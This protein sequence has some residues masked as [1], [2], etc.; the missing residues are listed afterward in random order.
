VAGWSAPSSAEVLQRGEPGIRF[1]HN[2][3]AGM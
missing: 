1:N 2:E 3:F